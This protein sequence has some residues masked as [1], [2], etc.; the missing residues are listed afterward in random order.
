MAYFSKKIGFM[1]KKT[2][3]GVTDP[4]KTQISKKKFGPKFFFQKNAYF[5]LKNGIS[6]EKT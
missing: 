4:Q 1:I 6:L 5:A 3:S 2:F